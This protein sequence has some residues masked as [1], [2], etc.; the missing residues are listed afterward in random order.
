[1]LTTHC[2]IHGLHLNSKRVSLFNENFVN[3]LNTLDSE[4]WHKDQNSEGN[5]TVNT[6]VSK[7]SVAT[8]NEIDD[9][10]KLGRLRKKHIKNLIFGHFNINSL[11]KK[12]E[13]LEPLITNHLISGTKF[14]YRFSGL[15]LQFSVIDYFV[16]TE[17]N[18]K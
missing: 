18:M 10:T 7:D 13:F 14:D 6:K 15:N 9:F 11:R 12:R 16:K 8:D 17:I 5:K 1:M 4:N 3:L 2:N